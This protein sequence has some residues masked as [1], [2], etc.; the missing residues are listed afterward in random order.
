VGILERGRLV[1]RGT[2]EEIYTRPATPFVAR[3]TGLSGELPVRVRGTAADGTVEVELAGLAQARPFHTRRPSLPLREAAAL[4]MIRPTGVQLVASHTGEHH[5]TGTVTDVAF[6]GRGYEHAI[7]IPGHGHLTSVFPT[8]G[9]TAASMSGCAWTRVAA[10]C[11]A[12]GRR[13]QPR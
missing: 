12:R 11:S 4:L 3:F 10:I 8:P 7:D 1:Q 6:R 5:V 13:R 9:R 2:P